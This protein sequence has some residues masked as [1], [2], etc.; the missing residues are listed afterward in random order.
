MKANK[1][2]HSQATPSYKNRAHLHPLTSNIERG[3]LESEEE[4]WHE[5]KQRFIFE[6]TPIIIMSF[7]KPA[8]ERV[9]R[10][11]NLNVST[12]SERIKLQKIIYLFANLGFPKL[13]NIESSYSRYVYGPY[14]T[15]VAD[16]AYALEKTTKDVESFNPSETEV[17]TKFDNL[18]LEMKN[19]DLPEY[20]KLEVLADMLYLLKLKTYNK[21]EIFEILK[22]KKET[23]N[24]IDLLEETNAILNKFY[25]I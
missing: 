20:L 8:V 18:F 25:P 12:L 22:N 11:M 9:I 10:G 16:V 4:A 7:D 23:F 13:E 1:F 21:D 15:E 17:V 5:S 3:S 2:L 6:F 14:S 24:N 19:I